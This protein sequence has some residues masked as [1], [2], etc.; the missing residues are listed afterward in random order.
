MVYCFCI[1]ENVISVF[2]VPNSSYISYYG[3]KTEE[4]I[5]YFLTDI[6]EPT[7]F[8]VN[9]YEILTDEI[10]RIVDNFYTI[11]KY[12]IYYIYKFFINAS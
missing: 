2:T 11:H 4:E 6:E 12:T 9:F 7:E 1:T 3:G 10:K 8:I 5:E